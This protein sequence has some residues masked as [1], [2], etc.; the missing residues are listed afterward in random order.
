[1]NRQL[2]QKCKYD[3]GVGCAVNPA[4]WAIAELFSVSKLSK[5]ER[6][7][8]VYYVPEHCDHFLDDTATT[9]Q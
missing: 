8:I 6:S 7:A 4:Y 2:C 1:M 3:S 5:Q 9:E